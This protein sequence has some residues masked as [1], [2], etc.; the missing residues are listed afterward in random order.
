MGRGV[1]HQPV[2][3]QRVVEAAFLPLPVSHLPQ[4][5]LIICLYYH[6]N[7]YHASLPAQ[8]LH[9]PPL[10]LQRQLLGELD[11]ELH[12][13]VTALACLAPDGH[14]L[15]RNHAPSLGGDDLVEVQVHQLAVELFLNGIDGTI[16]MDLASRASMRDTRAV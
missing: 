4:R 1:L 9:R 8:D 11:V 2:I 6:H 12:D 7:H 5:T 15:A 14:A 3:R 16:V 10:L 13:Q